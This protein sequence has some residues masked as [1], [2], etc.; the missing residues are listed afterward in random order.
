MRLPRQQWDRHVSQSFTA[1]GSYSTIAVSR[2]VAVADFNGDGIPDMAIA[3]QS[4]DKV[5]VLLGNGDGSFTAASGSPVSISGGNTLV[6][7]TAGDFNN[8]GYADLAVVSWGGSKVFIMLGNGNGTFQAP[9]SIQWSAL[10]WKLQRPTSTATVISIWP[11]ST[12]QETMSKSCSEM[13]QGPSRLQH[14]STGSGPYSIAVADINSDG[15]LDMVI[16]NNG[17]SSVTVLLGNGAGGFTQATGS[18]FAAGTNP[19]IDKSL[20]IGDFNGDGKPDL[21]VADQGGATVA[22]L[23]GNGDGTFGAPSYLPP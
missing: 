11:L 17:A 5:Y 20:V 6:G 1:A 23:L 13:A 18:P 14:Y 2:G 10:R 7:I 4:G 12:T 9:A 16:G 3:D 22:I 19:A 15:N 8:D 21:A